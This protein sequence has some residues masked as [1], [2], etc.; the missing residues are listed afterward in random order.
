MNAY[1]CYDEDDPVC[2]VIKA[3]TRGGAR[4]R[5]ASYQGLEF[6]AKCIKILI[7][8]KDIENKT[9]EELWDMAKERFYVEDEC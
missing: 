7:L 5:F 2:D 9:D 1:F 6:T 3:E 4:A 8:A